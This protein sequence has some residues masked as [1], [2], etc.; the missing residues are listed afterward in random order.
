[1]FDLPG[2][3]RS[4][5]NS[6]HRQIV[7]TF[8]IVDGESCG[9]TIRVSGLAE[10]KDI[11]SWRD[12]LYTGPVPRDLTFRGLSRARSRFWTNGRKAHELDKR[13]AH[14]KRYTDYDHIAL[15]F[16]PNCVLC[17]LSLMQLLSWFREQKVSPKLMSWVPLHG[18]ELPPDQ[19]LAAFRSRRPLTTAQMRLAGRVWRA[20]RQPTPNALARL[21]G[22]DLG[23]VPRLQQVVMRVLREYPSTRNGLSRLEGLLLREIQKRDKLRA[24]EAVG[25]I[26]RKETVGDMLL[27]DILEKFVTAAHPLLDLDS[28]DN[29][30]HYGSILKLTTIGKRVL[31]GKADS[32]TLNGVDRWIGGVHLQGTRVRWRWSPKLRTIVSAV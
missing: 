31:S 29:K 14:L 16:G 24:A 21:R 12:A 18:G 30:F 15:W 19:I 3:K 27:F 5:E 6:L 8:H 23:A 32:V 28:Q 2:G 13:D 7:K 22:V 25:A 17:Q 1:M 11:L 10:G 9:G 4:Q 20:F 26:L